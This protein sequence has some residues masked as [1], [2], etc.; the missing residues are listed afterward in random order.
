[1][2]GTLEERFWAKVDKKGP[3]ECWEWLATKNRSG[4]GQIGAGG[5]HG[6]FVLAHRVSWELA[7]GP[8]PTGMCVLHRFDNPGCV[9]PA[10]LFLGT[11]ADNL[12]DMMDKGHRV[13]GERVVG[14]KLTEQDVYEI[15]QMLSCGILE[16]VIA[17]K[18]GV[19]TATISRIKTGRI[20][21]WLKEDG[22][23]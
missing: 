12:R 13:C 6:K 7:N 4:Y 5:R 14:S 23:D 17:K 8:I 16:R 2:K 9:N 18:Y 1:M 3:D 21:G 19:T 22:D 10:H 15:R 20:W 11:Q